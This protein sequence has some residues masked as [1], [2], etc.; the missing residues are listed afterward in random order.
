M[1]SITIGCVDITAKVVKY[2]HSKKKVEDN[3]KSFTT[4]DGTTHRNILAV[5]NILSISCENLN[6]TLKGSLS[7]ALSA[8]TISVSYGGASG[9]FYGDDSPFELLYVDSDGVNHWD[10]SFNLEEV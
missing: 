4:A 3:A 7:T 2:N 5:K 8:S 1:T 6:D 9:T 10:L